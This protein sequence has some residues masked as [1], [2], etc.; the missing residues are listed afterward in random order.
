MGKSRLLLFLLMV[1][2]CAAPVLF[3][4]FSS[5]MVRWA[6][7][8]T[9]LL[10]MGFAL[11]ILW[12]RLTRARNSVAEPRLWRAGDFSPALLNATINEMR[13][14]LLV[15]DADMQVLASN[16]AAQALLSNFDPSISSRRL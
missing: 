11:G 15:I 10:I 6:G 13:E 3:I 16:R 5:G 9:S 1:A 4:L 12:Q 14:G 7:I 2:I 8:S